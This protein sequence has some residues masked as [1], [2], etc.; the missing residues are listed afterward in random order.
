MSRDMPSE[1]AANTSS[2]QTV[3]PAQA[4]IQVSQRIN[5][6]QHLDT[7]PG[8]CLVYPETVERPR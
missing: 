4:A 6:L 8:N 7:G 1:D 5:A 3:I 2:P